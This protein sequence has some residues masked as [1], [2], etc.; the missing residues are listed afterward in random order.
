MIPD[1]CPGWEACQKRTLCKVS[2]M[3]NECRA[4]LLGTIDDLRQ[5]VEMRVKDNS[6][7][8]RLIDRRLSDLQHSV[9]KTRAAQAPW[10]KVSAYGIFI[11]AVSN[12][13]GMPDT[14]TRL[15][16][17]VDSPEIVRGAITAAL[18]IAIAALMEWLQVRGR[19]RIDEYERRRNDEDDDDIL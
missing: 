12:L 14:V 6:R 7:F 5:S 18:G 11:I 10:V 19:R 3:I 8:H 13:T 15:I 1:E 16:S 9:D 17:H 4:A 2:E